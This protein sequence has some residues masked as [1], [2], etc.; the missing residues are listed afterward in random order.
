MR[1]FGNCKTAQAYLSLYGM[2]KFTVLIFMM[3]MENMRIVVGGFMIL[4]ISE[5][6]YQKNG[7]MKI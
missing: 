5:N 7:K 6:T 1:L 4:N 3:T 2:V